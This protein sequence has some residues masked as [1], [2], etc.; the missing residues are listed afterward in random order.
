[1]APSYGLSTKNSR[2]AP[3]PPLNSD[4][5]G[6]AFRSLS[7]S[8]FLGSAQRLGAGGVRLASF[9]RPSKH[10]EAILLDFIAFL[11]EL[12]VTGPTPIRVLVSLFLTTILGGVA[13]WFIPN[14]TIGTC[15]LLASV[16]LG[17]AI[18]LNWH[19]REGKYDHP[20]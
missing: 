1:M 19:K 16:V 14:K 4:P 17:V 15:V 7:A 13:Y 11:V 2:R 10:E 3:N 18:G 20:Q 8:R 5:A 12:I 9:V 6:I